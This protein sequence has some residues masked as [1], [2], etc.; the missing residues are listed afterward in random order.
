M[1]YEH[2]K[3]AEKKTFL[4]IVLTLLTMIAEIA[5]GYFTHS[6]AL[7]ADG[8]HMG[9][10]ALAL[11]LTFFTY[12][13]ITRFAT[14]DKFAFGTGKFSTLSGFASSILLGLTGI[15]II[16]ESVERLFNPERIGFN[17][18]ILVAVIGLIVNAASILIMGDNH[19][20]NHAA[21]NHQHNHTNEHKED[22][23][24]KAAYMH[25]LADALTS[26]FAIAAL[27]A[28]KYFN[29]IFLDPVVGFIG[30]TVIC[31][32][33]YNLI[34]STTAILVDCEDRVTK[35]HIAE[36]LMGLCRIE[37]LRV[38]AAS[39]DKVN[40]IAK[41]EIN[42]PEYSIEEIKHKI[43]ETADTASITIE[44]TSKVFPEVH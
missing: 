10:H 37:E 1:D 18:A 22:F 2:I 15:F 34:K 32:W 44:V 9:T 36:H 26:I 4:V 39:E 27:L 30:G 5:V 33:A 21:H 35:E 19:N 3:K 20:H 42:N 23:N 40:V 29:W 14:S 38:W 31:I 17:E 41:V 11:S 25:I 16:F 8:C 28:A 7:F 43:S 13:L 24:F 12:I 6:M